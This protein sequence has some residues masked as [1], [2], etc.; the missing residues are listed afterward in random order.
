MVWLEDAGDR[1]DVLEQ[2]ICRFIRSNY[3]GETMHAANGCEEVKRDYGE[4][5]ERHLFYDKTISAN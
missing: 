2:E 4:K 5:E 3:T 1:E